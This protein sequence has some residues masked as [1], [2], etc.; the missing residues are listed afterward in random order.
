M[1]NLKAKMHQNRFRLGLRPKP[2]WGAYT[3]LPRPLAG[4]KG[5][6]SKGRGRLCH[7]SVIG[8]ICFFLLHVIK[9]ETDFLLINLSDTK[10][11]WHNLLAIFVSILQQPLRALPDQAFSD[12][13]CTKCRL[14]NGLR[15]DPLGELTAL[16]QTPS[17]IETPRVFGARSRL[18]PSA[19]GNRAF[20]FFFFPF[21]HL[22]GPLPYVGMGPPEWLIRPCE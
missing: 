20:R 21:E 7:I 16:L 15:P 12:Q 6:T 10:M 9:W 8:K 5:L 3:A 13:K 1:S 22:K 18:T 2:R 17:C 11:T 14:A 4:F 19:L